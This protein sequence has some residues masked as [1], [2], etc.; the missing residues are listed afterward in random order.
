MIKFPSITIGEKD[1]R[2]RLVER[3][4]QTPYW[5][6]ENRELFCEDIVAEYPF[7]PPG[8]LQRMIPFEFHAHC[9]WLRKVLRGWRPGEHTVIIPTTDENLFWAIR[10]EQAD[11]TLG[12]REGAYVNECVFRIT[13]EN[14]KIK[15]FREYSNPHAY[16]DVMGIALPAFRYACD[17]AADA[18]CM[19]MGENE[20]SKFTR[21]Q[22]LKRAVDNY[23][24]P[25]TG[26]DGDPES[27]YAHDVVEVTPYS[28]Y[29]HPLVSAGKEFDVHMEWMFRTVVEWN[30]M[31]NPPF[32]QSTD[33][34]VIVV[35]SYGYGETAWS[36]CRGHYMQREL[37]I[38]HMDDRG[39]VDHFRVYYNPVYEYTSMNQNIPTIPYFN[40]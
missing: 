17:L 13:L 23:A 36:K 3:F 7:A 29:D 33:P 35:E 40:Y 28:A 24:N 21:E 34:S 11:M 26:H 14:G 1:A 5:A 38:A 31:E 19:R 27:I 15:F 9:F 4:L 32:Y 39:K 22:N 2:Y 16:Y 20:T 8:M 18:P 6:E 25:I 30:T 10:E 37:Q 12:G